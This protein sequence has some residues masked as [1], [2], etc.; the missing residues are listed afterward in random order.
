MTE[1]AI[2]P[3]YDP[4]APGRWDVLVACAAQYKNGNFNP[5][6]TNALAV[7]SGRSGTTV[8]NTIDGYGP[9]YNAQRR[10]GER[11][12]GMICITEPTQDDLRSF[13]PE[14]CTATCSNY[15]DCP[16]REAFKLKGQI[17]RKELISQSGN[18]IVTPRHG[19]VIAEGEPKPEDA[20]FG[21][22][23]VEFNPEYGAIQAEIIDLVTTGNLGR[24]QFSE[25]DMHMNRIS[26]K[27]TLTHPDFPDILFNFAIGAVTQDENGFYR[28]D[29][30]DPTRHVKDVKSHMGSSYFNPQSGQLVD[31]DVNPVVGGFDVVS[32]QEKIQM[33]KI[34][35]QE[36]GDMIE[37]PKVV[38]FGSYIGLPHEPVGLFIYVSPQHIEYLSPIEA[39]DLLKKSPNYGEEIQRIEQLATSVG[40]M[41]QH[42][43]VHLQLHGGNQGRV[44]Q[45]GKQYFGDWETAF[46]FDPS[47]E[48][49]E[50]DVLFAKASDISVALER[51]LQVLL[52]NF[53]YSMLDNGMLIVEKALRVVCKS[54]GIDFDSD[55]YKYAYNLLLDKPR[56]YKGHD[57]SK[58][59]G[60]L[61]FK[62][63][64]KPNEAY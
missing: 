63:Y 24:F 18:L 42:N 21:V 34:A 62:M 37:I 58:I 53:N 15:P 13:V 41:H 29:V 46:Y 12:S 19:S 1:L 10:E 11:Y 38:T 56:D 9:E 49:V 8:G 35:N 44:Y 43:L 25:D 30:P 40:I 47:Q 27:V 31:S 54:I 17:D 2:K 23:F 26:R 28:L 14:N 20:E 4:K 61:L 39:R 64:Y 16:L 22:S 52:A 3:A 33:T 32:L 60:R 36:I 6:D 55:L 48:W 50:D 7:K 59:A 51:S 45:S 57:I 5:N